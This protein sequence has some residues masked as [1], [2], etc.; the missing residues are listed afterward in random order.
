MNP[1]EFGRKPSKIIKPATK[2]L[3]CNKEYANARALVQHKQLIH[4]QKTS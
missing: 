2:C 4:K 1:Y 3:I